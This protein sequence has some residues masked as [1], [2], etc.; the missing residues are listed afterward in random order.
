MNGGRLVILDHKK[1]ASSAQYWV[2]GVPCKC[3]RGDW[4]ND[5]LEYDNKPYS[6]EQR[7]WIARNSFTFEFEASNMIDK[8]TGWKDPGDI[9]KKPLPI[10]ES[11]ELVSFSR[12]RKVD[13]RK[14]EEF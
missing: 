10:P 5:N 1:P 6:A 3:S 14:R 9:R 4:C 11:K 2:S 13:F 8:V 7:S 12:E